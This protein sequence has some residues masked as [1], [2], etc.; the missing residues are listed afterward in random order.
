MDTEF[1]HLLYQAWLE[2]AEHINCP[3]PLPEEE[4]FPLLTKML[5]PAPYD[6]SEKKAKKKAKG[7]RSG[8]RR[9]GAS[10][11]TSED[12]IHSSAAE[13]DDAEEEERDSPLGG[14]EEKG[15]SP[16][17]EAKAPKR[18]KGSLA[19]NTAWD[20]ESSLERMPRTKCRNPRT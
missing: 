6:V 17:L 18:G 10:D 3:A 4:E 13:D 15:A 16:N 5:F 14:K 19:D 12:E 1:L 9:K 20:V 8:L 7:G 2:V 11:V